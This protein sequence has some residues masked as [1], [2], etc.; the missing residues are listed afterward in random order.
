VA[1]YP[2]RARYY[3]P[4][5][6]QA[7]IE[8]G[9]IFWGVPTLIARH[10]EVSNHF[11]EPLADPPRAEDL[12]P[13][14]LSRVHDGIGIHAD[15]VIVL[16]HTCDFHGPE[17]GRKNRVRVVARIERLAQAGI[18]V[19]HRDLVCSGE[20][21]NHT[22]FLPS[23]HDPG[24]DADDMMVN[25]RYITTVDAAYLSRTR[26]VGRLSPAALIA[27][28]RRIAHF[29]TDYAPAPAELLLAD[30]AGGLVRQDRDLTGPT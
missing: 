17:K 20:G 26:R 30:T 10:P 28:R 13:P 6:P 24:R 22:F 5:A 1:W 4:V 18:D 21:F 11:A 19:Q 15:P 3:T 2:K 12:D 8:Q 9:D 27:F 25:L 23:W 14:P 29:F 7:E 16:P